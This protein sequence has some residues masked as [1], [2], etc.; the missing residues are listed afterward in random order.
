VIWRLRRDSKSG[1]RKISTVP[2]DMSHADVLTA[3]ESADEYSDF[4][5]RDIIV[6]IV[7]KMKVRILTNL[8]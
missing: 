8:P 5:V 3:L 2:V 4:K 6:V 7:F 1:F